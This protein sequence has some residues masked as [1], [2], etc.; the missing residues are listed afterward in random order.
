MTAQN[1]QAPAEAIPSRRERLLLVLAPLFL[2]AALTLGAYTATLR[3]GFVFDDLDVITGNQAFLEGQGIAQYAE[4]YR[5]RQETMRSYKRDLRLSGGATPDPRI[6]HAAGVLTHLGVAWL[7]YWLFFLLGGR[8]GYSFEERATFS[9]LA[10]GLFALHPVQTEAV[11]YVSGRSDVL[12]T[13]YLL[14]ALVLFLV[15]TRFRPEGAPRAAPGSV[16]PEE[17]VPS[18]PAARYW[19]LTL[20]C[21]GLCLAVFIKA[22][23]CKEIA[24][25]L[26]ALAV[27]VLWLAPGKGS[28]WNPRVVYMLAL[29]FT[30]VAALLALRVAAFSTPNPDLDRPLLATLCT[31]L[32][33]LV[34]YVLIFLFPFGQSADHEFDLLAGP[35]DGRVLAGILL[36]GLAWAGVRGALRRAPEMALGIAW[37]L[38]SLTPTTSVVP[39]ADLFVE[40]RLYLPSVGLCVLLSAVVVHAARRARREGKPQWL[41]WGRKALA[42]GAAG[43]IGL[44][45]L[46]T[47]VWANELTLW[48]DAFTKAPEKTRVV[49]N[50]GTALL[51]SDHPY[52]GSKILSRLFQKDVY[53]VRIHLNVA[54]AYLKIGWLDYAE[55]LYRNNVIALDPD[56]SEARYNLAVI[57][58]RKGDTHAAQRYLEEAVKLK[59]RMHEA[60]VKLGIYAF[61]RGE[62][63]VARD[64]FEQA[65]EAKPED[66]TAHRYLALLYSGEL[67]DAA[68]AREH[69]EALTRIE[70]KDAQHWFNLGVLADVE[71][72]MNEAREAYRRALDL[73]PG[74]VGAYANLGA[75]FQ[76][77]GA[78]VEACQMY[79]E[80]A[81]RDRAW[82]GQ[83]RQA[84]D[85]PQAR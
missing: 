33:A 75:L 85:R 37:F 80:A 57:A 17:G 34:R 21:W 7:L 12:A 45:V 71:N 46:R 4:K 18:L 10:A 61:G 36:L 51:K 79:R 72:R 22:L 60:L 84:C 63:R 1:P 81:A 83:A 30:G 5:F 74:H 62:T 40:R 29:L 31:N 35:L 19:L 32:W 70:P 56:N 28:P 43:L 2:I 52:E 20:A 38:V 78:P 39:I 42:V 73:D 49:F 77:M 82:A 6:F 23:L 50:L 11:A 48:S 66:P 68:K 25:V 3:A 44:T 59:P 47:H 14:V 41:G 53:D 58:E 26:P 9:S 13:L 69:L 65:A 67:S 24:A 15:P 54:G 64:Y 76:R 55:R 16:P 8:M 27:L